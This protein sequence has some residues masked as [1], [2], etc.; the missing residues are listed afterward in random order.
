MVLAFV[1]GISAILVPIF[2]AFDIQKQKNLGIDIMEVK[3][4]C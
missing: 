3:S 4:I 1:L 2:G